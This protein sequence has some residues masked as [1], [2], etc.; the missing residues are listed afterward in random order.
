VVKGDGGFTK[1]RGEKDSFGSITSTR[2][3]YIT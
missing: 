1:S 3:Y 2:I